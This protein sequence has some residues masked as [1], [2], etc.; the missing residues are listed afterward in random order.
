MTIMNAKLIDTQYRI[1]QLEE[2]YKQQT[3]AMA[4]SLIS[5]VDL[6][7]RYTGGHSA[8]VANYV[9][10]TAVELGLPDDE[11][12]A[13]VFAASLHDIG[14]IGIPDNIL[15]KPCTLE[16]QEFEWVRKHPEWGWIAIRNI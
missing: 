15:L 11:V 5:L 1:A 9:R 16:E 6:R 8:R 10:G 2:E 7:D 4:C 3:L 12:E 14:K 13:I